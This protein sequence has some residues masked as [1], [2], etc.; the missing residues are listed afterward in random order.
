MFQQKRFSVLTEAIET[1]AKIV[2]CGRKIQNDVH[3]DTYR[4]PGARFT[5]DISHEIQIR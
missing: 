4:K 2:D 3:M 5:K 1:V